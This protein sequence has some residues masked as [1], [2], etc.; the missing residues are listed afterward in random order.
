MFEPVDPKVSFP[1]L[2]QSILELWKQRDVMRRSFDP[3]NAKGDYVFYEGPPTANGR[4]GIHHVSARAI[5]DLYPRYQTMRGHRVRRRGGWDTHG[6]PVEV[7]VEKEI[8]STQKSDIERFGIAEFN[9]RCRGSVFRYIEDWKNLTERIGFWIDLDEAYITYTRNYIETCWWILKD[10]WDRDLLFE[11]FKVTMHCPRC[12]TSL[13][14]HEVSQGMTEGIDDPSVWAKFAASGD[15]VARAGLDAAAGEASVYFVAWTTTPWT[16]PANVALALN[17]EAGYALVRAP[18]RHDDSAGPKHLFVVARDLVEAT[19]GEESGDA[20]WEILAEATGRSLEGTRYT[21]ILRGRAA[22]G[23]D[24][25]AGFRVI[26]DEM[27]SLEDGTGVV[28]IAPAYGDL[29]VGN[30][31]GLPILFSADLTGHF[32]P[33]V[34][35][36][37]SD[38]APGKYAGLFFKD[39]DAPL[40][41]DLLARGSMYRAERVEHA[42]PLCWRD[43]SPLLYYA[44]SS[45]FIRT[46]AVRD[47]LVSI[48]G[49][50]NWVP[51]HVRTGRFGHWLEGNVDWALSRERYWGCPLPI[52]VSEDGQHRICVGGVEELAELSGRDLKDLDLHRP[53]IDDVEFD[54]EG[55]HYRR[56]P[57]TIDVW[58]ES[59]A[60]PYAQWHYPFENQEEFRQSFPADF[61]SEGVDQTR[62]WFYS[63]HAIATLLTDSGDPASGRAAGPLADLGPNSPAFKNCVVLGL[64][65]DAEGRKMSKSLG[66]AV[67]PASIL[68]QQGADVLRWYLYS[69]SNADQN[70]SFSEQHVNDV[71]RSFFLTLWNIY[72]FFVLYAEIDEPDLSSPFPMEK[73]PESD[74][75]LVA[76]LHGLVRSV[77]GHLDA[78]DVTSA[79]RL[80]QDFVVEDLSNW[81]VRT[82][83]RRFWK[84]EEPEDKLAA[85]HTLY[86]ALTTVARL[87]APMAPFT[88]EAIYQN[89]ELSVNPGLP[90]SVHLASWPIWDEA[91]I[92]DDLVADMETARSVIELARSARSQ[93]QIRTRQ[94]LQRILVGTSDDARRVGVDRFRDLILGELNVKEIELLASGESL[95][96]YELRPNLPVVGKR[97]GKQVP[98][99]REALAT[100]DAADV[101]ARVERGE[102]VEVEVSGET[103]TFGPDAF[104]VDVKSPEG[105]VAA[106][107]ND[108]MVALD[109]QLS[110]DLVAEGH[111]RDLIRRVQTARKNA[112]I[113]VTDRIELGLDLPAPLRDALAQHSGL[114]EHEALVE[115]LSMEALTTHDFRE[116]S[117]ML[118]DTVVVTLRRI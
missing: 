99:F 52:W 58:F 69:T 54:R 97:L 109:T 76:K 113:E 71:L 107:S 48:N 24:T 98:A 115:S 27:V 55:H 37:G 82:N 20:G 11:D 72:G 102:D 100:L 17:P 33:E 87:I 118:G 81:Y 42:Y 96:G 38:V 73:R 25:D 83:R 84:N 61:I 5:K 85:H 36:A 9:E 46:T 106:E 70:K 26:C 93:A 51:E 14:D 16:L 40:T 45:W 50:I 68:D 35:E 77:T 111:V 116:E 65:N 12:N 91:A 31:H 32:F 47:Q 8:G 88:S 10:L 19:F 114:L 112:D 22:E 110:D 3:P 1:D 21:P 57:Y 4:P 28:H 95:V 94:P 86:E 29:E 56:V 79:S 6:L 105:L 64:I 63:L 59:G 104:L 101:A 23:A 117:S 15:D 75:W 30:R 103:L 13:A 62:G 66:N 49:D 2:E 80:I 60:M 39:A 43:G 18:H 92:D 74:R 67:D 89:L 90:D 44:K 34:G 78:Y 108:T 53:H 7:E 41:L